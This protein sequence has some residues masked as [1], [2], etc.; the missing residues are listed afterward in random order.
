M[1]VELGCLYAA[2]L[3]GLAQLGLAAHVATRQRGFK[4]NLSSREKPE[5]PLT[6]FA[7]RLDRSYRNFLETFV[8]F[9][10]AILI[11]QITGR[12]SDLSAFGARTYLIARIVYVPVYAVGIV[13]LR[14]LI[15]LLSVGGL[16]LVLYSVIA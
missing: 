12:N 15:W 3:L 5:A 4:W 9:A 16:A 6:G 7:G 11:V 1:S 2:V 14:S 13:G 8:F 10:A